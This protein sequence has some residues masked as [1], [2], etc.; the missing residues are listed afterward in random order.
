MKKKHTTVISAIYSMVLMSI[1]MAAGTA[2]A[3]LIA[4]GTDMVYDTVLNITWL[5]NANALGTGT[6]QEMVDAA[7]D[8]SIDYNGTTY[9]DW[10]LASMSVSATMVLLILTTEAISQRKE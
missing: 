10:R 1:L 5:T 4:R 2:N 6:W 3:A 8:Y 9:D 7:D